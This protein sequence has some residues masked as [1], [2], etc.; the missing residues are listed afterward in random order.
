MHVRWLTL[1]ALAVT[2]T[3]ACGGQTGLDTSQASGSGPGQGQGGKCDG[4]GSGSVQ[5]PLFV[6]NEGD[7][8]DA[9]GLTCDF[10]WV[11]CSP[12]M[13]CT[14]GTWAYVQSACGDACIYC[15]TIEAGCMGLCVKVQT[16]DGE[17]VGSYCIGTDACPN[18]KIGCGCASPHCGVKYS[19]S[20]EQATTVVCTS[21]Q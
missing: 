10:P 2:T 16:E 11:C 21:T 20:V 1:L 14:N 6:P 15:G 9:P 17:T 18:G 13:E 19:I 3:S 4:M 8:C 7:P 5:C 12:T